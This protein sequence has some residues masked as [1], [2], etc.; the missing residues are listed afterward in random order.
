MAEEAPRAAVLR[1]PTT[2]RPLPPPAPPTPVPSAPA[3]RRRPVRWALLL[4]G[5]LAVLLGAGYL[6]LTGGRYVSIDNAY[7][8][9]EK[10]D[11]AT[12]ISGI[13]GEVDVHDN[14]AVTAGQLLFRLDPEPFRIALAKAEAQ[15]GAVR[16]DIEALKAS[17]RQK[18]EQIRQA[19]IDIAYYQRE[20][21]RQADLVRRGAVPVSQY[22]TARHNLDGARQ[23]VATLTQ[24]LAG[25][26][27]NLAGTPDIPVERHPR[28]LAAAADRDEIQRQLRHT[29][30]R[31][32]F[33]GIVAQVSHLLPG[34]YLAAAQAAFSLIATDHAWIEANPKETE[35]T[36]VRPGQPAAITVDTYPG[37]E[38]RGAV[39]SLS[40]ASGA[41]FALLPAQNSSGNW[42]KVVQRIPVRIRVDT[43]SGQPPL[44]AGMSVEVTIDT[45]HQRAMPRVLASLLGIAPAAAQP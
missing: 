26:A 25:I 45:G 34:Q 22:D 10:V 13:V 35:L 4:L 33:A 20:Y 9:A 16:D 17:Y 30:V 24:D 6:Y 44:R 31:A 15:L 5:P 3:R 29:E 38:W 36:W 18:Q 7:I 41:Q 27:A 11:I 40:P 39:A 8:Q 42:V 1:A 43:A 19:Q 14:Q 28:Y 12:D 21:D 32:P 2:E 23:T 37:D